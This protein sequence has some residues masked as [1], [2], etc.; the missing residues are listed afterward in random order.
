MYNNFNWQFIRKFRYCILSIIILL[1]LSCSSVEVSKNQ[2]DQ[3]ELVKLENK[4]KADPLD[5]LAL[6]QL[7]ILLVRNHQNEKANFYLSKAIQ[8][9]PN[10]A[11]LLFNQGLNYEFLNDTL[12]AL[13]CYARY[14][15]TPP[16]SPYRELM[17]GRYLYLY[18]NQVYKDIHNRIAAED[19]LNIHSIPENTLA[20]F[21]LSYYGS[22]SKY[23]PL[24]RG[25]SE[26]ISI[27]LSKVKE[28]TVLERIR[29]KAIMDELE[30]SRLIVD[31]NS[32]PRI[33]KLLSARI[34]Y[35]G[36]FD[37]TDDDNLKMN[38]NSWD[39]NYT[40]TGRWLNKTGKLRDL[41]IIEKDLVFD[42]ID[43]LGIQLTQRE[44][45]QIELIPTNNINAFLEYSIGLELQDNGNYSEAAMFFF[46]ATQMDPNFKEALTKYNTAQFISN[47]LVNR[48]EFLNKARNI[49]SIENLTIIIIGDIIT[50]RLDI[51][52]QSIKSTF[53][54]G[55]ENRKAP[56]EAT[57][58]IPLP[59][60]PPPPG[61]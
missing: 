38:I 26:M 8:I 60:P 5:S 30:Y 48:D 24:S 50:N 6:K 20:V 31:Q 13:N 35:D 54:Q 39:I 32:A 58:S 14:G 51:V 27:D 45:E 56:Q 55:I 21:P 9:M 37:I 16:E 19:K 25:L 53:N 59:P 4:V 46:R 34:L 7:S 49:S 10:D 42:I 23:R 44:I 57:N 52:D 28:L 17:E 22:D 18:R 43:D 1:P 61:R 33:G 40:T 15:E 41:F 29:L 11:A 12:S 3:E 47:S 36:S 2:V